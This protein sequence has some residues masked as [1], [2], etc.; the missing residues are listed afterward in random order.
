VAEGE[1]AYI[2]T[3]SD[4]YDGLATH[5]VKGKSEY[6]AGP[7]KCDPTWHRQPAFWKGYFAGEVY[8]V[9]LK[10]WLPFA[11]ELTEASELDLRR[12][13]QRGQIWFFERLKATRESHPPV[14]A[15]FVEDVPLSSL[16][17]AFDY[18]PIVRTVYHAD[19]TFGVKSWI[20]ERIILGPSEGAAPGPIAEA[21]KPIV[22]ATKDEVRKAMEAQGWRPPKVGVNGTANGKPK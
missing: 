7:G 9:H 14:T 15:S 8:D 16:P 21:N 10:R 20:P 3:L 11:I 1:S 5:R 4:A 22:K 12:H 18:R 2:R 6:C 19:C 17:P 13:Y